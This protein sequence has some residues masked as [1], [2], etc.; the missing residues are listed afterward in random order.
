MNLQ[1]LIEQI[2]GSELL[3]VGSSNDPHSSGD[4]SVIARTLQDLADAAK[5]HGI[6]MSVISPSID[7]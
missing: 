2:L 5:D 7:P 4:I 1:R 3:Q 6:K